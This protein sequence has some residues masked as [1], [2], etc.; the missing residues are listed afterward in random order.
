M[1]L[2]RRHTDRPQ[3]IKEGIQGHPM[4]WYSDVFSIVFPDMN[5]KEVSSMWKA[6]LRE[7]KKSR[8]RREKDDDESGEDD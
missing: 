4:D 1:I 5:T 6:Q 3:N 8:K 2:C 7:D